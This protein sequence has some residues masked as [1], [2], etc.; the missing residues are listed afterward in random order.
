MATTCRL[1]KH[2]GPVSHEWCISPHR[3]THDKQ[4]T[5]LTHDKRMTL[6]KEKINMHS[7]TNNTNYLMMSIQSK[8]QTFVKRIF[9][10]YQWIPKN[11]ICFSCVGLCGIRVTKP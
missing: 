6:T 3:P 10:K 7:R 9:D 5:F 1:R 8:D 2:K 11:G 4:M